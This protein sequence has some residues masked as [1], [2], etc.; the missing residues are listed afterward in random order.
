MMDTG[1]G[2]MAWM[3][4]MV[5]VPALVSLGLGVAIGYLWGQQRG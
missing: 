1:M 4:V 3:L 5:W 2:G